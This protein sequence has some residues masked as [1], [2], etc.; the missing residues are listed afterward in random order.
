M[1]TCLKSSKKG[2]LRRSIILLLYTTTPTRVEGLG[3][4]RLQALARLH[5]AGLG[6]D[7]ADKLAGQ[8]FFSRAQKATFEHYMQVRHAMAQ[9]TLYCGYHATCCIAMC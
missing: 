3:A 4:C 9:G 1:H 6:E 7:W 5:P 8:G 2:A